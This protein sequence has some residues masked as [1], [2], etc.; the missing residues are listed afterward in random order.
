MRIGDIIALILLIIGVVA[1]IG[2]PMYYK[3]QAKEENVIEIRAKQWMFV[4]NKIVVKKGEKVTL[5]FTSDDVAHGLYIA[6]FGIN[7]I[8]EPGKWKEVTFVPNKT[9]TFEIR[10][11]IY[12]GEPYPNSGL[13][14]WIMRAVLVVTD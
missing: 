2:G 13:G 10:C 9:G 11:N 5:R 3:S 4:P 6:A 8:V 12:C 7:E 14:H 1:I